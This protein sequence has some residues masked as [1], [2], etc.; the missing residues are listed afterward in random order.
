MLILIGLFILL[1]MLGAR[2][3]IDL[4]LVSHWLATASRSVIGSILI[5]TGNS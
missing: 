2:M 1:P 4:S 3:G 5:V